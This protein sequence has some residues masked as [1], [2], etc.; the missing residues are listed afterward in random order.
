MSKLISELID[1]YYPSLS[2]DTGTA[3]LKIIS[4]AKVE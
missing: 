1:R 3:I 4:R 2:R